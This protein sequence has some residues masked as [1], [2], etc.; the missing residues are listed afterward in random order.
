MNAPTLAEQID[1]VG[2]VLDHVNAMGE[3]AHK[4]A[5]EINDMRRRLE[6]AHETLKTLE[7]ARATLK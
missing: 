1:A 4:L 7:F 6:A 5:S 3:A 2:W